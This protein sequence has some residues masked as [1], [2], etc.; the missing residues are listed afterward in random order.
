MHSPPE[1]CACLLVFL[2]LYREGAPVRN[3]GNNLHTNYLRKLHIFGLT[4]EM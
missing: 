3:R 4:P 2:L 1:R